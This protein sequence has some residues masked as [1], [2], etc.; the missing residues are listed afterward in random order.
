MILAGRR[1]VRSFTRRERP[2]G[3]AALATRER[4]WERL[5]VPEEEWASL[6]V[7]LRDVVLDIGFGDGESLLTMAAGDP[8]RDYVGVEVYRTGVIKVLRGIEEQ[9]PTNVRL[10]EADAHEL[11]A[12]IGEGRIAAIQTFFPDPWPK[13]RHHKRRLVQERFLKEVVRVLR[14]GGL[15]HMATDWTQYAEAAL[16]A[17]GAFPALTLEDEGRG[18]R[19]CTRF[20]RRGLRLGHEVRDLRFRKTV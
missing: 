8:G 19:P 1:E 20:E 14:A 17:V 3:R 12:K 9:G 15:F 5:A 11:L 10:I 4:L 2:L 18:A 7:G 16:D 13:T 6:G